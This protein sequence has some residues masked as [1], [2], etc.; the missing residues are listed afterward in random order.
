M[1]EELEGV[2]ETPGPTMPVQPAIT[3]HKLQISTTWVSYI[4]RTHHNSLGFERLPAPKTFT[5]FMWI[6]TRF[7]PFFLNHCFFSVFNNKHAIYPR[8]PKYCP[9]SGAITHES[10]TNGFLLVLYVCIINVLGLVALRKWLDL[11]SVKWPTSLSPTW[12]TSLRVCFG[13]KYSWQCRFL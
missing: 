6:P 1:L 4:Y 12:P 7:Q 9:E 3:T 2:S 8:F 11:R 13:P 5:A 10:F